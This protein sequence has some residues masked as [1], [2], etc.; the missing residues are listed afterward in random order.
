[1]TYICG[2]DGACQLYTGGEPPPATVSADIWC[3]EWECAEYDPSAWFEVSDP[4]GRFLCT[5]AVGRFQQYDCFAYRGGP[6]PAV[7]AADLYCSGSESLPD[8]S[9]WWYPDELATLDLIEYLGQTHVC[10][11][12]LFGGFD[13]YDCY[14][15]NG[16]DP[17]FSYGL[18]I[19]CTRTF[20]WDCRNDFY[21]SEMEGV[22]FVTI[23][24]GEYVCEETFAGSE[25]WSYWGGSPRDIMWGLPDYYCNSLGCDPF[26]YP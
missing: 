2:F 8:C 20:G 11:R 22:F 16:G 18:P 13:D 15:Y 23:G 17:R 14:L 26:A 24:G 4:M 10:E 21:P 3:N 1:L 9:P 25:C 12:A 6:P 19:Y 5:H 7:V